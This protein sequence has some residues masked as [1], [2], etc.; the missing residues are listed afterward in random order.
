MSLQIGSFSVIHGHQ[1]DPALNGS[2]K[3]WLAEE[4]DELIQK[5]D[6]PALNEIRDWFAAGDRTNRP[7]I[8]AVQDTG[9]NFIMGHSHLET[10]Q[11]LRGG[12]RFVNCGS[13]IS[14]NP[15]YVTMDDSGAVEL[16]KWQG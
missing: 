11:V 16:H 2:Y 3:R 13:W 15:C 4:A 14:G 6:N 10:G 8:D 12:G 5:L 1:F 9:K 7:L